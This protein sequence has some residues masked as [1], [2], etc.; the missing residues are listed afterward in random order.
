LKDFDFYYML[1]RSIIDRCCCYDNL[2]PSDTWHG[3]LVEIGLAVNV[4]TA[5]FPGK[6]GLASYNVPKGDG[7]G[8]DNWS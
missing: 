7:S 6:P 1:K 8:G 5:I 4:L 2:V 3:A